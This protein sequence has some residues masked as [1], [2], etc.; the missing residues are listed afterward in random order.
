ME[1]DE[2]FKEKMNRLAAALNAQFEE[3]SRLELAI[4]KNLK[5]L[6]YPADFSPGNKQSL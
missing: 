3:S 1:D 5:K 6:A 2:P 4:R